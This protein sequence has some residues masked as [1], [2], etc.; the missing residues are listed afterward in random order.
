M[1][2]GNVKVA[3]NSRYAP[4]GRNVFYEDCHTRADAASIT[5]DGKKLIQECTAALKKECDKR[6]GEL[7]KWTAEDILKSIQDGASIHCN[8]VE[9]EELRKL[10]PGATVVPS[11]LILPGDIVTV[12][13]SK[14]EAFVPYEWNDQGT[15]FKDNTH[16][17]R[18][19][20]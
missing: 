12:M 20:K 16:F 11:E 9:E 18:I 3:I 5:E 10:F 14:A 13:P 4:Y 7:K 17:W 8:P 15:Q 1:T 19:L 2:Q 6:I